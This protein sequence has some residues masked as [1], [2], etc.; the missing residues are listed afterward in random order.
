MMRPI[1]L[2]A[3]HH[4]RVTLAGGALSPPTTV[5]S[6]KENTDETICPC[7]VAGGCA[8]SRSAR[9]IPLANPARDHHLPGESLSRQPFPGTAWSERFERCEVRHPELLGGID[10]HPQIA[11]SG[12]A[13]DRLRS[14]PQSYKFRGR[15][16]HSQHGGA[17][18]LWWLQHQCR[19]WLCRLDLESVYV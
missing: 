19:L 11:G 8:C 15:I 3:A 7:S 10:R 9:P 12:R 6:H 14:Q 17:S 18:R 16:N 5:P 1:S 4:R 2:G 13:G